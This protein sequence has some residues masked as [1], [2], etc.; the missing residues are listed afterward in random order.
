MDFLGPD[1]SDLA[2][3]KRLNIT[4]LEYLASARG[5]RLRSTLPLRLRPAVKAMTHRHIQRLAT[6]PFLLAS[7][8]ELDTNLWQ[9]DTDSP[10]TQDLFLQFNGTTRLASQI[11]GATLAF[12]WQLSRRNSYAARMVSGAAPGW[13]EQLADTSLFVVL[14][15]ANSEPDLM[16]PR[17][18]DDEAFWYRLL[19][20]GLSSNVDICRAA[21][22]SALQTVLTSVSAGGVRRFRSAACNSA[23]PLLQVQKQLDE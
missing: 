14:Q 7:C 23:V 21:H 16:A 4:F 17:R 1:A 12:L 9:L 15:R 8:R 2:D 10:Q 3:V 6:A 22:L 19:G 13:C 11:A 20:A 5:A 18:A